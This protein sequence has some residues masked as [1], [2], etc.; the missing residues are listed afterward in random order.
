MQTDNSAAHSVVTNN[1]QTKRTEEMDM[2][3]ISYGSATRKVNS[4]IIGGQAAKI[5]LIIGPSISQHTTT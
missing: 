5:G 3:F 1:V 2:R 4:D